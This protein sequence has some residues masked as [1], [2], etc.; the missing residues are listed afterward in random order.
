M[1][2]Y[3]HLLK[4]NLL[5]RVDNLIEIS[6]FAQLNSYSSQVLESKDFQSLKKTSQF[7]NRAPNNNLN[8]PRTPKINLDGLL[9]GKIIAMLRIRKKI[10]AL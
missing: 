3:H 10:K 6:F 9:R 4:R 2:K 1:P 5:T 8:S 7:K